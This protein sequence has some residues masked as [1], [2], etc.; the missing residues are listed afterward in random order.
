LR[1]S[2]QVANSSHLRLLLPLQ[3][4][5]GM[6]DGQ[7]YAIKFFIAR[8]AFDRENELYSNKV[9]R[10]M[11]P[12]VK[13]IESNDDGSICSVGGWAFPPCLVL[14]RGESLDKWAERLK[15]D[16]PTILQ[17]GCL[18]HI[19]SSATSM[20]DL[21]MHARQFVAARLCP[22]AVAFVSAQVCLT[23]CRC[24]GHAAQG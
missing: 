18:A 3:F 7:E 11:M 20:T 8:N 19:K 14:E 6:H 1:G 5:R 13:H 2:R 16:F 21:S 24:L 4:A 10:G 12:A 9:L 15:P 22:G 17:V 23:C